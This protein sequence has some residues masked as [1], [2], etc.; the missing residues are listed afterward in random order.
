MLLQQLSKDYKE[1][2]AEL[3]NISLNNAAVIQNKHILPPNVLKKPLSSIIPVD[4]K[5]KLKLQSF[6][7]AENIERLAKGYGNVALESLEC[8]PDSEAKSCLKD[9]VRYFMTLPKK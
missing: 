6:E 1:I 4:E 8:F 3:E 2:N 7:T 5:T 9:L